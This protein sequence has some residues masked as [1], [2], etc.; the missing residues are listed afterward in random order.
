MSLRLLL[1]SRASSTPF[2]PPGIMISENTRS[3]ERP[4]ARAPRAAAAGRARDLVTELRKHLADE[5]GDLVVV[6]DEEDSALIGLLGPSPVQ[7]DEVPFT[8]RDIP[9]SRQIELDAGALVDDRFY[10]N[11]PA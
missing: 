5:R 10:S 1:I 7:V 9:G 4:S 8:R 3:T 2:M 11:H 6:F